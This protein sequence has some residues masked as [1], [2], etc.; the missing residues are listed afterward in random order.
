MGAGSSQVSGTE[1]HTE[2]RGAPDHHRTFRGILVPELD[3]P[4]FRLLAQSAGSS[5]NGGLTRP[6]LHDSA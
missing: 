3:C 5:P 4:E 6:A 2:H 1:P